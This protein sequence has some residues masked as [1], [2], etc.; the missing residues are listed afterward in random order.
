V[1][2]YNCRLKFGE[3]LSA[4]KSH[5]LNKVGKPA[6]IFFFQ[7]GTRVHGKADK[8]GVF[9]S[10]AVKYIVGQS[11]WQRSPPRFGQPQVRIN[12]SNLAIL[13]VFQ[14]DAQPKGRLSLKGR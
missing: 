9:R 7:H 2:G 1:T 12:G 8:G 3:P 11:V 6:L 5:V 4:I 13:A 10:V 14:D